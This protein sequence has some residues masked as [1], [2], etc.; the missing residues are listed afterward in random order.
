MLSTVTSGG[1]VTMGPLPLT[2][3]S[4]SVESYDGTGNNLQNTTWGSAGIDLLRFAPVAYGDGVSTPA[5]ADLASARAVSNAISTHVAGDL[6]NDRNLTAMVYAWGQFLDHDIDLTPTAQGVAVN[7][8]VPAGDP[9]FDPAGTGTQVI[10][11][12][13]AVTDPLTGTSTS[14]PLNQVNTITAYID[15]S[16]VY[17]SDATRAAALRTFSGGH[18]KTSAGD[19]L[20][21]NTLGLANANDAHIVAGDQLFLAGDVRANENVELTA[22]QTLFVREHNRIADSLAAADP[23]LSDEQLYQQARRL[24]IA[25]MQAITYNEFLP[26]L[27]GQTAMGAYAGYDPTVNPSISAEFSTAAFRFGHS[28]VGNDI[29][30]LDN[31]GN[32]VSDPIPFSQ[33]FFNPGVIQGAG[34]DSILKYSVTDDSEE[35]DTQVVD[36]LRNMLFGAPGSGGLDLAA[37]NIQRGREMGLASYNA[38]RVAYGLPAVTSF[39]QITSDP[40]LQESLSDVYG[41]DVD[42]VD[43]WV[44][45]L[46]EDHPAGSSVGETFTR[47]MVDQFDRLRSGD[48]FWY[49]NEF[50]GAQLDALRNTTLADVLERNT[51]LTDLQSNVFFDPS[52][53]YYKVPEGSSA[54]DISVGVSGGTVNILDTRTGQALGTG[55]V[56]DLSQVI[57][58]GSNSA[59]QITLDVSGATAMPARGLSVYGGPQSSNE[60][61]VKGSQA[62]DQILVG[63]GTV[64][65]DGQ[66]ATYGGFR[67]VVVQA[68][69][70]DDRITVAPTTGVGVVVHG[71]TG[72]DVV[73]GATDADRPARGRQQG[74]PQGGRREG[75]GSQVSRPGDRARPVV[76]SASPSVPRGP[77]AA[78]RNATTPGARARRM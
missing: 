33:A 10:P 13:R 43:L 41:G 64:S 72:V 37:I 29:E 51:T 56:A 2:V 68:G 67:N 54:S 14:N 48:R 16:Q 59:H 45:G 27:L 25:E 69:A 47:I 31:D 32:P 7:I 46:A 21:L 58:V 78:F 61:V 35:I 50:Q 8:P 6:K 63:S 38:T 74:R 34:I 75:R 40:A 44:G 4:T 24:V 49:E 17:G 12:N 1:A 15:G 73:L 11:V 70:G 66:S 39:S 26:A 9:Q 3:P 5:G 76:G 55:Q 71:G 22:L 52:V 62:A 65:V 19:L 18:L 60:L 23:A 36:S 30:F 20:P 53:L 28:M 42:K 57:V 77:A